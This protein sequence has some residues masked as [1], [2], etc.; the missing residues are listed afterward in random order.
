M[1]NEHEIENAAANLICG[2]VGIVS[3]GLL[4][5]GPLGFLAL[6]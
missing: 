5:A 1:K 3:W 6:R 4:A 2:A